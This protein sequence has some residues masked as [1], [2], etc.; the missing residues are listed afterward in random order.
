MQQIIK[1][2]ARE[3]CLKSGKKLVLAFVAFLCCSVKLSAQCPPNI[4]FESGDFT[5][6]TCYTG[7]VEAIGTTNNINL[8]PS[9]GPVNDRHMII[10]KLGSGLDEYGDFPKA[11]PNGSEFSIKLGNN[12]GGAESEGVSYQFTIPAN[13]NEFSLIYHYAVVFQDPGHPSFQQPRLQIDVTNETDG[14]PIICSSFSFIA[15]SNMPGFFQSA[16]PNGTAPVWCKDW[17]A[18]SVNLDG[19]AGKTI[20]LFFKTADCTLQQHF[21][22][23][24][25]D[26]NTEC[27]S[28]F[29]GANFCADDTLINVQAPAGYETY[30]WYNSSFTQLLGTSQTL[31]LAPPPAPGTQVAVILSPFNGYG[32][33][34]TLYGTLLDTLT[35][36]ADAGRDTFVCNHQEIQIGSPPKQGLVYT[37]TPEIGLSNPHA[38]NPFAY[39]DTNTTY[40]LTVRHEGGG[41]LSRD[42]ILV[43]AAQINPLMQVIGPTSY[44]L[45]NDSTFLKVFPA[46]SIQWYRYGIPITGA[47]QTVYRVP[48]VGTYYA[49]LF[50]NVGCVR[51]TSD[52]FV[53]IIPK[54]TA[55]FTVDKLFSCVTNNIFFFQSTTIS[56]DGNPLFYIWDL[57]DGQLEGSDNFSYTYDHAGQYH[58]KMVVGNATQT[59]VDSSY[60]TLNVFPVA[61]AEFST[62][63]AVC[64][65][66]PVSFQNL[67]TYTGNST[68]N[69]LWDFGNGQTSSAKNPP[70]VS[71]S[72]P[73]S[74]TISLSA[75]SV[76]C[77]QPLSI[78]THDVI[79]DGPL[80]GKTYPVQL[81]A[82]NFPVPL[83]A[84]P[85]G[86]SALWSPA[87]NLDNRNIYAPVF[88][89]QTSQQYT[90]QLKT[91]SG[92]LTV[93]TL[94]VKTVK[95]IEIYVPSVF[96]P[97]IDG[98]ND[99]LRPLLFG[100]AKVNYFRV[101]NR[102]GELL[103]EMK[104]DRP[105]W[106]GTVKNVPQEMQTVVWMI[107]AVDVDGFIHNR[108][109]TSL[110]MR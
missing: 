74:H 104:T 73:G 23:A 79:I 94:F 101:Y 34:D 102:W 63:T 83:Q 98:K 57:D 12:S 17:S 91:A 3:R 27:S 61:K 35:V 9:G 96:T 80:P 8:F 10:P 93:D 45:G 110:L 4:D 88:K 15:N 47:N 32:C 37:W 86:T 78:V 69:Y 65:N 68:L 51:T 53:D 97:G 46:D 75:T 49:T 6:W 82:Y 71:F 41:C 90:I 87:T 44:C 95:K 62:G 100:I 70:P 33:L 24:Y 5:G 67:S 99:Y 56:P 92:C 1:L 36:K 76:Q 16:H 11:C 30:K 59:C 7:D 38:A 77:P 109:G 20:K 105:G 85:I 2:F 43:K 22:Y 66:L 72:T 60:V 39:S 40:V 81:A 54:P 55:T 42:T 106:D 58:V 29:I 48:Q 13:Q 31:T 64:I 89:G 52:Q 14:L 25:I 108:Q 103:F 21:G 26:V 107:E 18:T 84:R 28:R 50:S 19:M